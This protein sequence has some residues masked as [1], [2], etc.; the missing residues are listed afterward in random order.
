MCNVMH[1]NFVPLVVIGVGCKDEMEETFSDVKECLP[2]FCKQ[3]LKYLNDN[4]VS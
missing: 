3:C 2:R 1:S 4:K